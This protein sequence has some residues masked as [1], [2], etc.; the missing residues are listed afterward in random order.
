VPKRASTVI[1]K[2]ILKYSSLSSE[3]ETNHKRLLVIGNKQGCGREGGWGM[4]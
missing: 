1:R 3:R 2:R 4:G